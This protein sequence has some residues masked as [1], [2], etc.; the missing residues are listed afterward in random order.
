M[1]IALV[2]NPKFVIADRNVAFSGKIPKTRLQEELY[3][4]G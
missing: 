1:K 4:V 2:F 3:A